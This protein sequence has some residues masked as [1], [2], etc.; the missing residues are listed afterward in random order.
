MLDQFIGRFHPLLVHIPIGVLLVAI[1]FDLISRRKAFQVLAPSVPLLYLIGALGG[2]FSCITG[3]L[4]SSNGEY[5]SD[6]VDPHM[7]AGIIL[8]VLAFFLYLA[9]QKLQLPSILSLTLPISSL[10]LLTVT[11][12]LGGNLTH[13]ETYLTQHAPWN[14]SGEQQA[15]R[16][17]REELPQ[18]H[19]YADIVQPILQTKCYRCHSA[20]KQK[21][22]L[23]LDGIAWMLEGGKTGEATLVL[24]KADESELIQRILLP[25]GEEE[26][27]PPK[28]KPQISPEELTILSWWIEHGGGAEAIVSEVPKSTEIT[29]ALDRIIE[30]SAEVKEEIKTVSAGDPKVI[31]ALEQRGF[32]ILPISSNQNWLS[33]N[34]LNVDQL[35]D[36]DWDLMGKLSPQVVSLKASGIP[37]SPKSLEVISQL[38]ELEELSLDHSNIQDSDLTKLK[39]LH[40]LL[41][42][43]ITATGISD[44]GIKAILSLKNLEKVFVFQ[45]EVSLVFSDSINDSGRIFIERGGYMLR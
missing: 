11:G 34:T 39:E 41:S 40:K 25:L 43:N 15:F 1:G 7:W 45:T 17:T 8:T 6:Q 30:R 12:H 18:A 2:A 28:G 3:Y 20:T 33:V 14:S 42:L 22:K 24:G 37:L 16:L 13:G 38:A 23:R 29:E 10:I 31:A 19:V 26:H 21:G 35:S 27:M 4:L 32:I 5:A 36:E 9:K 44:Q